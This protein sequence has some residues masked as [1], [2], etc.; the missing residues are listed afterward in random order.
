VR[1]CAGHCRPAP[2]ADGQCDTAFACDTHADD[3]GDCAGGPGP[4]LYEDVYVDSLADLQRLAGV[5]ELRGT[6][7][8]ANGAPTDVVLPRLREVFAITTGNVPASTHRL[9]LPNLE[10]V[11]AYVELGGLSHVRSLELPRLR[12][13]AEHLQ[14]TQLLA[15][16]VLELPALESLGLRLEIGGMPSLR[17]LR[18]PA[19]AAHDDTLRLYELLE[20]RQLRLDTLAVAED[21]DLQLGPADV[22]APALQH[23]STLMLQTSGLHVD[24]DALETV[25]FAAAITA[26]RTRELHLPALRD[27]GEAWLATARAEA[28]RAPALQTAD[29]TVWLSLSGGLVDLASLESATTLRIATRRATPTARLDSLGTTPSFEWWGPGPR[30]LDLP[31]VTA[32]DTLRLLNADA[33]EEL[34]APRLVDLGA[35]VLSDVSD[36]Q[37]VHLPTLP[38]GSVH[39]VEILEA[40]SL[41]VLPLQLQHGLAHDADVVVADV[42]LTGALSFPHLATPRHFVIHETDL[43]TLHLPAL[44]R[45]GIGTTLS[46]QANRSLTQVSAGPYTL[47]AGHVDVRDNPVLTDWPLPAATE[48]G[49]TATFSGN[50]DLAV[51]DWHALVTPGVTLVDESNRACP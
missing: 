51:C 28:I 45:L 23:A 38:A 18:L 14:L 16:P 2:L 10:T 21:L 41:A 1:D 27:V 49:W 17:A 25:T 8:L 9:S 4:V 7:A 47:A 50:P 48:G 15:L 33:V 6:L 43:A 35:L 22:H 12:H 19:L 40:P 30:Q 26:S 31:A 13:V 5:E 36:L 29:G 42:G 39:Y 37:R 3:L 34:R 32:L 46:L 44:D 20:L 11:H 24:L